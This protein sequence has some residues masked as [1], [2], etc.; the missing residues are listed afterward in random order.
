MVWS[1]KQQSTRFLQI[2]G[3]LAGG[4]W[5]LERT[6]LRAKFPANREKYRE[7]CQKCD[8]RNDG[9]IAYLDN[10]MDV[11]VAMKRQYAKS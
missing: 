10:C 9:G 7:N 1:E 3:N 6:C 11:M 4:G 2:S 5:S 8:C